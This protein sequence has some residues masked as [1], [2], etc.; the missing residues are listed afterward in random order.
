MKVKEKLIQEFSAAIL[1]V[2]GENAELSTTEYEIDKNDIN[3]IANKVKFYL[4]LN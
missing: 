1:S 3:A 2:L 4:D